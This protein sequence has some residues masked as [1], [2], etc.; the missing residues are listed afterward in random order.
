MLVK[1]FWKFH[2]FVIW[3]FN[4]NEIVSEKFKNH[5]HDKIKML[6]L[7]WQVSPLGSLSKRIK[8]WCISETGSYLSLRVHWVGPKF[9]VTFTTGQYKTVKCIYHFVRLILCLWNPMECFLEVTAYSRSSANTKCILNSL[10]S[11][12]TGHPRL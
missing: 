1:K 5:C 9:W 8:N 4:M 10:S 12:R 2:F 7:V 11:W 3:N 6:Q